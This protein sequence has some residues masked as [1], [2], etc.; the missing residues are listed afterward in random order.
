MVTL[1]YL[2]TVYPRVLIL[3][4]LAELFIMSIR[5]RVIVRLVEL[6]LSRGSLLK[7]RLVDLYQ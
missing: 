7:S 2:F 3:S 6:K 5:S 1:R 4:T